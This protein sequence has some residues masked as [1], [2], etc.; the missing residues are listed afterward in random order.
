MKYN[1]VLFDFDYTLA[2][3]TP[4]IVESATYA[5]AVMGF[6]AP[7]VEAVR[8]TVGMSLPEALAHLT[9]IIDEGQAAR[10]AALYAQKADEVMTPNTVLFDDTIDVLS[11]LRARGVQIGIVTSK[12]RYRIEEGLALFDAAH[13]IDHI[14]GYEDVAKPKPDPE[15]IGKAMAHLG[16]QKDQVLFVGDSLYDANAA[17]NAGVDFAAVLNGTTERE[18]FMPLPHIL[19]AENLTSLYQA[20]AE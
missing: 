12:F 4:G 6:P 1:T 20:L 9:G 7:L 5:L 14:V 19:I 17:A 18:A 15:G 11:G 10:Y 3:A 2:D 13:L 16:C 8:R